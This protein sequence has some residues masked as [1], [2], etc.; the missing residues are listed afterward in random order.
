MTVRDRRWY[1]HI[2]IESQDKV[3][4]A[5]VDEPTSARLLRTGTKLERRL[6]DGQLTITIP[7]QLRT[8]LVDVVAVDW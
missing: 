4:L 8:D 2:N 7:S 5:G 3:A 1:L 6:A